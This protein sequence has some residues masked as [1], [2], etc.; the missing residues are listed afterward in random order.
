MTVVSTF[1]EILLKHDIAGPT[2]KTLRFSTCRRVKVKG[3]DDHPLKSDFNNCKKHTPGSKVT[4]PVY[5]LKSDGIKLSYHIDFFIILIS[6][7]GVLFIYSFYISLENF[8]L[9]CS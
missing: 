3:R 7:F 4:P 2:T 6:R 9:S 1:L 8:N 5:P